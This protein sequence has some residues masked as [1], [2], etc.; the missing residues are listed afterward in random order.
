MSILTCVV[1]HDRLPYTK[2]TIA[3]L[4][5]AADY[6]V[7]V[8]N[9]STD[10]TR[11]WLVDGCDADLVILNARNLYPGAATNIG[12]HEGLK[13]FPAATL[14]QRSDND[15]EYASCWHND[16]QVAFKTHARLGLYGVLNLAEDFPDGQPVAPHYENGFM[17]NRY[18]PRLGGNVVLRRSLWDD[19][20][21]W[22][23]GPWKPGGQ[24]EDGDMSARVE[25][26]G[27]YHANAIAPIASNVAFGRYADFPAYY[28]KTA[29]V[30]GLVAETSV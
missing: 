7:V 23:P 8:D 22:T 1:T 6:L 4:R 21:R 18:W 26:A 9:A 14:L 15:I 30:R 2:R 27:F 28:D 3:S 19:G 11:E 24:D 29:A 17:V 10:G 25:A 5:S 20:L 16:V 12:W 13:K